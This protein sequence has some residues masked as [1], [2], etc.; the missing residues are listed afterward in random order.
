VQKWADVLSSARQGPI[1]QAWSH[2]KGESETFT[3]R[4]KAVSRPSVF[5]CGSVCGNIELPEQEARDVGIFLDDLVD[6]GDRRSVRTSCRREEGQDGPSRWRLAAAP[7]AALANHGEIFVGV[8]DERSKRAGSQRARFPPLAIRQE[9][10]ITEQPA[11]ESASI[12][13]SPRQIGSAKTKKS[14]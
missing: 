9:D 10:G 13:E 5:T 11:E 6:G 12:V 7:G 2:W 4:W 14:G 8:R 3:L 1:H